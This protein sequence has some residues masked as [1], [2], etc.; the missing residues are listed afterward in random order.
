M[1]SLEIDVLYEN[2]VYPTLKKDEYSH[3]CGRSPVNHPAML[4]WVPGNLCIWYFKESGGGLP[5]N[6]EA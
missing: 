6:H 2:K 5:Q 3:G 4:D 1:E